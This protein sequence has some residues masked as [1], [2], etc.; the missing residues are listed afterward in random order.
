MLHVYGGENHMIEAP[1]IIE[2]RSVPRTVGQNKMINAL[3][4][5]EDKPADSEML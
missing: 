2:H 4:A 1:V 5:H 3:F